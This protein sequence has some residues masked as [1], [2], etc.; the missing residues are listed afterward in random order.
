M[1]CDYIMDMGADELCEMLGQLT[2][3]EFEVCNPEENLATGPSE[4]LEISDPEG[5]K[6]WLGFMLYALGERV[7]AGG[8]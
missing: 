8:E 1:V 4:S 7:E 6:K 2:G 5:L 3:E